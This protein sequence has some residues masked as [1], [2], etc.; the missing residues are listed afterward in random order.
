[1]LNKQL[2]FQQKNILILLGILAATQ[3]TCFPS[4][5]QDTFPANCKYAYCWWAAGKSPTPL[6]NCHHWETSAS[7]ILPMEP[8]EGQAVPT[9]SCLLVTLPFPYQGGS[10]CRSDPINSW[11]AA[12]KMVSS[13]EGHNHMFLGEGDYNL[14]N[15]IHQCEVPLT[16][17]ILILATNSEWHLNSPLN[18]A[19]QN[20][21]MRKCL[22]KQATLDALKAKVFTDAALHSWILSYRVSPPVAKII[23][24]MVQYSWSVEDKAPYHSHLPHLTIPQISQQHRSW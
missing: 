22:K 1:M 17:I 15:Q 9:H 21:A 3:L 13:R 14:L 8:S 23:H 24:K 2:D 16:T 20:E 19:L 18:Q 12:P 6:G 7:S 4:T 11:A 5:W 10:L